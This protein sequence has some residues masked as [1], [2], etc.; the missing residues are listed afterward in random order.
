MIERKVKTIVSKL[1]GR[2]EEAA[3]RKSDS[4]FLGAGICLFHVDLPVVVGVNLFSYNC[5]TEVH[6]VT[7]ALIN[8]YC[9]RS[10][11]Q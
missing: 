2:H 8:G 1:A 7:Q 5:M 10:L 11:G 4:G 9:L 6:S 3:G